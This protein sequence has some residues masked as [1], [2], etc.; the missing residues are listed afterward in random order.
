MLSGILNLVILSVTEIFGDFQLKAFARTH[1]PA[2]L[3]KGILG[4]AGVIFFLVQ[5]LKTGN[6]MYVNGMWD[7]MSGLLESIAA[8]FILGERLNSYTQYVGM[9][10]ITCGTLLLHLGGIAPGGG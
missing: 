3:L 6:V 8:Y 9:F 2:S 7:G 1:V 4:Y 5:S 10:M